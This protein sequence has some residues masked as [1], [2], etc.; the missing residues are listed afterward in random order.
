MFEDS[1]FDLLRQYPTAISDK[2]RF[3]GLMKDY[4]P[5]Q[6]MQVNLL[7]SAYEIGIAEDILKT[8]QI[9]NAFAF[10]FVK[11]LVEEYG[12][13]R[14]NAD[15]AVSLW[16]VCYGQKI[17]HKPCEIKIRQAKNGQGPAIKE[18]RNAASSNRYSDLFQY[19]KNPDGYGVVGFTGN[20]KTVIFSNMHNGL[21]VK[22]IMKRAFTESGIEEAVMTDGITLVEEDAFKGCTCLRQVIF[23]QTLKTIGDG[24]FEGCGQLMMAALPSKL[25]QIGKNAFSGSGIKTLSIPKSVHWL[26]DGAYSR[27]TKLD[28][29]TIPSNITSISNQLFQGCKTLKKIQLHD[30][31]DSIG[32]KAFEGCEALESIE[33]PEGVQHIGEDAFKNCHPRL[34]ILC[35]R[36]SVAEKYCRQNGL[37]FQIV[38]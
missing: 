2:K 7:K 23:A 26:G 38:F 10:R 21:P 22:R 19:V 4:F 29:I 15:W 11:R 31:I 30:Q 12:I 1:F 14:M 9:S 13:S 35:H 6:Q 20:N 37:H 36:L 32:D 18:E 34:T 33:I 8:T 27:C 25:E 3:N 17:L 16:C 5:G 24:A 28:N